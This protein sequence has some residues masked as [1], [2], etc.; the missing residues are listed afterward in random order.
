M[1]GI[2]SLLDGEH[3]RQLS[4]LY[5]ELERH[6][7][8]EGVQE[9]PYPH[10]TYYILDS[11]D[12]STVEARMK[13]AASRLRPIRVKT[14]GL[15]IFLHPSPVLFI[16]VVR[17]PALERIHRLLRRTFPPLEGTGGFYSAEEWMPHITLARGDLTLAMLPD[18]VAM[19]SGRDFHWDITLDNLAFAG[20]GPEGIEIQCRCAFGGKKS[21]Q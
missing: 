8:L 19:L 20:G 18:V 14:A 17:S 21:L 12:L 3:S 16:Q 9:F 10:L 7:G 2:L 11:Y 1:Q 13:D 5:A 15:G 6:F 4:E